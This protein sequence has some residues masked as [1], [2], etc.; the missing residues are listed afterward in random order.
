MCV[1]ACPVYTRKYAWHIYGN[2]DLR[3]VGT[4]INYKQ[5]QLEIPIG[6]KKPL[7]ARGWELE[8]RVGL[9]TGIALTMGM[10]YAA[11]CFVDWR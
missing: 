10:G 8:G 1:C 9:R 3:L 11:F 4:G 5:R 6:S 2:M 7:E